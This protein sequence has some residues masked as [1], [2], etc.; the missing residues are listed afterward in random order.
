MIQLHFEY[1]LLTD[2]SNIE[3]TKVSELEFIKREQVFESP[4]GQRQVA[5]SYRFE[6]QI[7]GNQPSVIMTAKKKPVRSWHRSTIT[8]TAG[9]ANTQ[10]HPFITSLLP[11]CF[12]GLAALP[13]SY[14]LWF[15]RRRHQESK[16][17]VPLYFYT[18][19]LFSFLLLLVQF[20]WRLSPFWTL[21][22]A[23]D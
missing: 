14:I 5:S 4:G 6:I 3:E 13:G 23:F 2:R 22:V 17:N 15:N 21:F 8:V 10:D 1:P 11:T 12:A 19:F 20:L 16:D 7:A 18:C 9:A